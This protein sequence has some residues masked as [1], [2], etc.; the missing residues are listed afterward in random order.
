MDIQELSERISRLEVKIDNLEED[1]KEMKELKQM[2][3]DNIVT[4]KEVTLE[5]KNLVSRL[6]KLENKVTDVVSEDGNKFN[7]YKDSIIVAAIGIIVAFLLKQIG[8]F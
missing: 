6:D 3:Y 5:V 2:M 1:N 7:K 8:I 4:S